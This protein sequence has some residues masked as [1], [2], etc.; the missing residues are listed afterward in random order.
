MGPIARWVV[1]RVVASALAL[2]TEGLKTYRRLR[3]RAGSRTIEPQLA[4]LLEEEER[5]W[6][7]LEDAAAGRL[8]VSSLERLVREHLYQGIEEIRPLD[9]PALEEWGA[10]LEQ[11]LVQEERTFVFYS[12]L[13]RISKIPQVRRAFEVMAGM[14][15]EHIEILRR[16]LGRHEPSAAPAPVRRGLLP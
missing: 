14:E 9:G 13:R 4:H 11:A 7:I 16:L 8:D 12:N 1:R 15:R 2:E 3:D 10:D 5:H 6:R